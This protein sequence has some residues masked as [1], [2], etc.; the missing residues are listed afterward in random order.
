MISVTL[1]ALASLTVSGVQQRSS[2]TGEADSR[3]SA[4]TLVLVEVKV[5]LGIELSVGFFSGSQGA[6]SL[7]LAARRPF[8]GFTS[9]LHEVRI[10]GQ[11][12][13]K[14]TVHQLTMPMALG[15]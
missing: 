15:V 10:R 7:L 8:Y 2:G 11:P 5:W 14:K 13:V 6:S 9:T 4:M 1:S 3:P 12:R